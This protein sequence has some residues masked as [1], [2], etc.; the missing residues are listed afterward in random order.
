MPVARGLLLSGGGVA[1]YESPTLRTDSLGAPLSFLGQR[2]NFEEVLHSMRSA[3]SP[4][5]VRI[6]LPRATRQ[7]GGSNRFRLSQIKSSRLRSDP[8]KTPRDIARVPLD[9]EKGNRHLGNGLAVVL[10]G[11][12][13]IRCCESNRK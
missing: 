8:R 11:K 1:E 13:D 2:T 12:E 6:A 4:C 5:R 9:P 3:C 10:H 7:T